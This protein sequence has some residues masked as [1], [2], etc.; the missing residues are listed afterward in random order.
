MGRIVTAAAAGALVLG[1]AL[2]STAAIAD[3][4]S[5]GDLGEMPSRRVCMETAAKVLEDYLNE[6]G[7]DAVTG[8]LDDNSAWVFY[9]WNLRP[10][11]SNVVITC[12]VVANQVNAFFTIHSAGQN[13][14]AEADAAAAYL[15]ELWD[16]IY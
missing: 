11:A 14:Q 6:H 9:A 13:P 16:R 15:R 3:A 2:T 8:D 7:G 10:G 4:F 12:P 1:G 5:V